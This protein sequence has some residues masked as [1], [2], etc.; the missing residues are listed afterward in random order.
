MKT[1]NQCP[2]CG[3]DLGPNDHECRYCGTKNPNYVA[4]ENKYTSTTS[5]NNSNLISSKSRIAC[6]IL[7]LCTAGLGIGRFYS[8][9]TGIGIAQILVTIFTCGYGA[10]WP[11]IDG[12]I[13]LCD[14]NFKDSDGK[15]MQ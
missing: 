7:Q 11:M 4:P 15:I 6:G 1:N 2:N 9:H 5:V 14:K 13:I 12:V 8:G 3:Y 10:I